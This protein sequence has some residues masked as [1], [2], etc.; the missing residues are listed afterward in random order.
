MEEGGAST[1]YIAIGTL[2]YTESEKPEKTFKAP[3]LLLPAKLERKNAKSTFSLRLGDEE[4]VLNPALIESLKQQYEIELSPLLPGIDEK[5]DISKVIL[6]IRRAIKD[7][8]G[9]IVED[10]IILS[11]FSFAKYL[12]WLDIKNN[13]DKLK[14]NPVVQHLID[15]PKKDYRLQGGLPNSNTLDQDYR[16]HETFCPL[17]ADSFQMKAVYA[18]AG[19]KDFIL[20]GPPGTGKS[21]TIANMIVQS[22][23]MGKSILFVS[24]KTAAR[25]VVYKRLKEVGLSDYC[26]ELHSHKSNKKDILD[27]LSKSWD[28]G[29]QTEQDSGRQTEWDRYAGQLERLREILNQYPGRLHHEYRRGFTPYKAIGLIIKNRDK[30]YIEIK[31]H[32]CDFHDKE[33]YGELKSICKTL[34]LRLLKLEKNIIDHPLTRITATAWSP[35]IEKDFIKGLQQLITDNQALILIKQGLLSILKLP[36]SFIDIAAISDLYVLSK[37]LLLLE[38]YNF[39]KDLPADLSVVGQI[40]THGGSWDRANAA[41]GH[42][43]K[44]YGRSID[45]DQAIT[46]W[47]GHFLH[48]LLVLRKLKHNLV[49]PSKINKAAVSADLKNLK[50]LREQEQNIQELVQPLQQAQTAFASFN[51]KWEHIGRIKNW[52]EVTNELSQQFAAINL[53]YLRWQYLHLGSEREKINEFITAYEQ[54]TNQLSQLQAIASFNIDDLLTINGLTE[55]EPLVNSWRDN[56]GINNFQHWCAWNEITGQAKQQGLVTLIEVIE[57]A[58]IDNDDIE[59]SFERSYA[60]W[61]IDEIISN[62]EILRKFRSDEHQAKITEFRE[63]DEKY[64]RATSDYVRLKLIEQIPPR[65]SEDNNHHKQ[66][67]GRASEEWSFLSREISKKSKHRPLRE[68][69]SKLKTCLTKLMPCLLMSPQSVAQYLPVGDRTFDVVIFDEASQIPPWDAIGAIGRARQTIIVGDDKQMPPTDYFN[70]KLSSDDDNDDDIEDYGSILDL[71]TALPSFPKVEL[72]CHYR[73]HY[74][75]LISFSNS[76]Y[77]SNSLITFPSTETDRAVTYHYCIGNYKGGGGREGNINTI[78]AEAVVKEVIACLSNMIAGGGKRSLGIVTMNAAQANYIDDLLAS[79]RRKNPILEQFFY[80]S[81]PDRV[82]VKEL[83]NVQG[84]ERDIIFISTTYG[85]NQDGILRQNFGPLIKNGGQRRLNV[86]ITRARYSLKLFSSMLHTDIK[87]TREGGIKDLRDFIEFAANGGK[88]TRQAITDSFDSDFEEA[89]CEQLR[90]AGWSVHSQVGVSG[91]RIDLGIVNPGRLDQY[92][93]GIECD[94]AQYHSRK[95]ARDR[96]K[97]REAVLRDKGWHIIRIWG[98]D[99]YSDSAGQV[100]KINAELKKLIPQQV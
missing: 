1:L 46:R 58:E 18:A 36:Q 84:D 60:K 79:E 59:G 44:Y 51:D 34:K 42:D 5:L 22:M 28:S 57:N 33:Q 45:I 72:K 86:A 85:K 55:I 76:R 94:G 17:T 81:D 41:L 27:Q 35:N 38:E 50:I 88:F 29:Q 96:D 26:L 74:E 80:E 63:V 65:S 52:A 19:N 25:D 43:Y 4:P 49:V 90:V 30:K 56:F 31:F 95:S 8:K 75:S 37:Q 77:Y 23:A 7:C 40:I 9:W 15:T 54:F 97:I 53:T 67:L 47:N 83:E 11:N 82:F 64:R 99:W 66:W 39:D 78:E 6:N 93:A 12:M 62:D 10:E 91:F 14:Q 98:P 87:P 89:V 2:Y 69:L 13:I 73:S 20:I 24:E 68:T 61:W 100:K 16:L 3:L 21:Q 48:K 92:I 32:Q 71:C 70:K